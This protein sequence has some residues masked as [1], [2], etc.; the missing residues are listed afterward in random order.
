MKIIEDLFIPKSMSVIPSGTKILIFEDQSFTGEWWI[1]SGG[2]AIFADGD[3]GDLT[4][5]AYVIDL[6]VREVLDILNIY[7]DDEIYGTLEGELVTRI[8]SDHLP[9]DITYNE[10]EDALYEDGELIG[11]FYD[12]ISREIKKHYSDPEKAQDVYNVC[13]GRTDARL[14]GIKHLEMYRV[15]GTHIQTWTLTQNDLSRIVR[16]LYDAHP[17]LEELEEGPEWNIEVVANNR[18]YIKV[19]HNVLLSGNLLSISRYREHR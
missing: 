10:E 11:D 9:D 7:M 3:I 8:L 19:P 17:E 15:H 5:E 2:S 1:D 12:W 4:H 14:Y 16:G 6:V 13:L 18:Y